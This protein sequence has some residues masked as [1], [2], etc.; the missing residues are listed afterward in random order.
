[1]TELTDRECVRRC[2]Q[3]DTETF[4]IL[5]ERY[6]RQVFKL[7]FGIVHNYNDAEDIAQSVFLKVYENLGRYKQTYKFF[8]WIYRIAVNEAL[9]FAERN[10]KTGTLEHEQAGSGRS[11]AE[12]VETWERDRILHAA[13]DSLD[14]IYRAV[15][16]LKYF[17]ELPYADI[18][19]IMD[20]P[21]KRV[22]SRL[23]SARQVI[24]KYCIE[25]GYAEY[26]EE[27]V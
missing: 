3:G 8:S 19:Y 12:M 25:K 7:V 4:R 5:V 27:T 2:L 26:V 22:K 14:T 18:A 13:I 10:C 1:M 24:R 20:I 6:Q 16:V 21:E 9:N 23:F 11:P 15:I 17:I